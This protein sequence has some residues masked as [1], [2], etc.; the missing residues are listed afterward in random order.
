V[1]RLPLVAGVL[2]GAGAVLLVAR[3]RRSGERV[4]LVYEDGEQVS[5]GGRDPGAERVLAVARGAIA[6][7]R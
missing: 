6:S 4:S 2:A 1:R 7:A 5:L 3:S